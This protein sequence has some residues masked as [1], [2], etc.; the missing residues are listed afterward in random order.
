MGQLTEP[1]QVPVG[2]L[3]SPGACPKHDALISAEI[4]VHGSYQS[5]TDVRSLKLFLERLKIVAIAVSPGSQLHAP[6]G[7]GV[8]P[9][10]A[11]GLQDWPQLGIRS[12]KFGIDSVKTIARLLCLDLV[13]GSPI[14]C[15]ERLELLSERYKFSIILCSD[16]SAMF[17]H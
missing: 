17:S 11:D 8:R 14:S 13:G 9:Q 2:G 15:M 3:H 10:G 5:L 1:L 6:A 4:A 16:M 7:L 12:A